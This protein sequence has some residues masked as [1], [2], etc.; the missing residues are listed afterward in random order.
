VA[1][2]AAIVVSTEV[3]AI[4]AAITVV[5]PINIILTAFYVVAIACA[6]IIIYIFDAAVVYIIMI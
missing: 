3:T 5:I 6:I 4:Y 1:H 2:T